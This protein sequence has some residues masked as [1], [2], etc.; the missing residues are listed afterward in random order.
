MLG[1]Q[2][3]IYG[4]N[5]N[6][7]GLLSFTYTLYKYM[8]NGGKNGENP[9]KIDLGRWLECQEDPQFTSGSVPALW[10]HSNV[11]LPCFQ[12]SLYTN[13]ADVHIKKYTVMAS[14]IYSYCIQCA[15]HEP[16]WLH[17]CMHCGDTSLYK[18]M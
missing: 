14:R 6:V 2:R 13:R 10:Q 5:Y 3:H 1:I 9:T 7:V 12:F 17:T 11:T 18:Y 15:L 4:T 16:A 8:D